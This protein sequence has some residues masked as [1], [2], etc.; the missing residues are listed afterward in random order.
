MKAGADVR[1]DVIRELEWDPQAS[2]PDAISVTVQDGAVTLG[3]HAPTYDD[4]L[5]ASAAGQRTGAV[6]PCWRGA[7]SRHG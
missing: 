7:G 3:G 4:K 5:A 2:D 6:P 1:Q